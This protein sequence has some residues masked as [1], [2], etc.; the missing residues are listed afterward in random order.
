MR[1]VRWLVIRLL[2][3]AVLVAIAVTGWHWYGG[4]SVESALRMVVDDYRLA[5]ACPTELERIRDFVDR[6]APANGYSPVSVRHGDSWEEQ[7][8][9]GTLAF[10]S[11][12]AAAPT[13]IAPNLATATPLPTPDSPPIPAP[14]PAPT[15]TPEPAPT[16]T[17][18]VASTPD[19]I[20]PAEQHRALKT[21]MLELTNVERAAAGLQPLVLG[22]NAA[23]QLH[24]EAALAGC[25]LSHWGLDGLKPYMRYSLAGGYQSN[26]ENVAGSD[27]CVRAG[28]GYRALGGIEQE[29][30]ETI[31]GWMD[32]AGHRDNILYPWH[33]KVNV[34]LA[35][36]SYN[37]VAVQHFEGDY[38]A[39]KSLPAI[40][41]GLLT[42]SG[43]VKNG[44]GFGEDKDL[45]VRVSYDPPPHA[46][47]GGQVART[48]CYDHG[49]PVAALRPPLTG[50]WYYTED[51]Y[52]TTSA[53]CPNPYD[54]PADA[55]DAR[56]PEEANAL[57][58][59]A[60][61]ASQ[62]RAE[63]L[64]TVPWITASEWTAEDER[65]VVRAD[66][67]DLLAEHGT[68]I[69]SLTVWGVI[70]GENV[71]ISQYS[72]FCD[73]GASCRGSFGSGR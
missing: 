8:C 4:A 63:R 24:A 53:P 70:G 11:P 51:E 12:A 62:V 58:Q 35:W 31:E 48:Y 47:T 71:V 64:V 16:T 19:G 69:Y 56:S 14:T 6:P 67:S 25:F 21:F 46:L 5:A 7:V 20:R 54:A 18:T 15:S 10:G 50:G 34:G 3:L 55:P 26:G 13:T 41:N 60:Y 38:V 23:A 66:L 45:L 17:P 39:Y 44:A 32:S 9:D 33:R 28:D 43:T 1:L 68:G 22:E 57:W 65:F 40:E 27:Y 49:R 59:E 36:D 61:D 30:R 52:T 2:V 72:M 37:L 29:I 42:L 73:T